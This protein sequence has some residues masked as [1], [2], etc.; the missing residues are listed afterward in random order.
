MYGRRRAEGGVERVERE[1][2]WN[3]SIRIAGN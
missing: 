3:K 2:E 1:V